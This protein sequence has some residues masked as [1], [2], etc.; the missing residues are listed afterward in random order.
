MTK[1]HVRALA[2]CTSLIAIGAR[3]A[4]QPDTALDYVLRAGMAYSD[5]VFRQSSPLE[6]D[7]SSIAAGAELRGERSTGRLRYTAALDF[8]HYEYINSTADSETLGRGLVSGS[9]D[10]LPDHFTW[11]A[12]VGFDQLRGDPLQ[13]LAP[14]NVENVTTVSTGPTLRGELFGA[15]DTQ[16][17]GHY[18]HAYYSGNTVDNQTVGGQLRLGRRTGPNSRFGLGGSLDDVSYLGGPLSSA[19]DFQRSEAFLYG[20]L[21]GARTEFSGEVGY[22]QANGD[23]FSGDGPMARIRLTRKMSPALSAYV[24]YRLEYPTSQPGASVSDPTAAGGGVI[25]TSLVTSS[26]RQAQT[27]EVGFAYNRTRSQGSIG[28]YRLDEKSLITGLGHHTYDELRASVTR[29]FTP[30]SR[31]TLYASYS[32]E[33]F[34]AFAQSYDEVRGGAS[35]GHDFTRSLGLDVRIEYQDRSGN[36]SNSSYNEFSGGVFLRYSGS[37]LGRAT[38]TSQ[39]G[40][41]R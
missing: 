6:E 37:L 35:F 16:L 25:N 40:T 20:E 18:E 21:H 5:N 29:N 7:S 10:F 19:L 27:G 13:P 17:D 22:S 23:S 8:M 12:S 2:I 34:S 28:L 1:S 32:K 33:D 15:V 24:G 14:G 31:G 38:A 3:A 4:D 26:P 30:L 9:Y 36:G 11:N 41:S 39:G